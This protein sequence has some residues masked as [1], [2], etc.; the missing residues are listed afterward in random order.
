VT[1]TAGPPGGW[2]R[3]ALLYACGFPPKS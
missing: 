3:T 1:R 2:V